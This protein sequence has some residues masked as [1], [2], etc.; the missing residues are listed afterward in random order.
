MPFPARIDPETLGART[1]AV[2]EERGFDAWSLRDVARELGV[3]P[4]ALYRHVG[5]REGLLVE[6]AAQAAQELGKSLRRSG[7]PAAGVERVVAMS[8]RYVRFGV[9][10]PHAYAAFMNAKPDPTHPRIGPWLALWAHVRAEA[11]AVVPTAADAAGFALWALLH[12]RIQ[13][14]LGPAR[15]AAPDSGL[16]DAVRALLAGFEACA[17][18]KSPLP[19]HMAQD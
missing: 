6:A 7:L 15:A 9:R 13:L 8:R 4:N 14:A 17:P 1:L 3:S 5:S 10:R 12:G 16:D 11:A 18:V 2:V 19:P